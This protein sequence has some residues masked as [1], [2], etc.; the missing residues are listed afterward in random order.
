MD[1]AHTPG[2]GQAS[3]LC[4]LS[5]QIQEALVHHEVPWGLLA[6]SGPWVPPCLVLLKK[7]TGISGLGPDAEAEG[8][9]G[10]IRLTHLLPGAP[11]LVSR[12]LPPPI[13]QAQPRR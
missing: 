2:E 7:G 1:A 3:Y 13:A 8:S 12:L 4:P 10:S 5:L 11:T 6:L 9:I